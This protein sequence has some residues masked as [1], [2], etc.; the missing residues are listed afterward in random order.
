MSERESRH[1]AFQEIAVI[2]WVSETNPQWELTPYLAF[3]A[4]GS[5][6]AC[7]TYKL[8]WNMYDPDEK[9]LVLEAAITKPNQ[10]RVTEDLPDVL[11]DWCRPMYENP[12]PCL[13]SGEVDSY[14]LSQID[15]CTRTHRISDNFAMRMIPLYPILYNTLFALKQS[16]HPDSESIVV[17]GKRISPT[18]LAIKT[19]SYC[20]SQNSHVRSV[21]LGEMVPPFKVP[22]STPWCGPSFIGSVAVSP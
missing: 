14:R 8:D 10:E 22:T 18:E 7:E 3:N 16:C 9:C 4:W 21:N 1:F 6:R 5:S 12:A 13:R 15:W 20:C 19:R 17:G 11:H 2:F